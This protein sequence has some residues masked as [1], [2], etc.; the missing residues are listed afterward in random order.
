MRIPY[1][2]PQPPVQ[3]I[4]ISLRPD[5]SV[6]LN[7]KQLLAVIAACLAAAFVSG[8]AYAKITAHIDDP[9]H[10]TQRDIRELDRRLTILELRNDP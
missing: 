6:R 2:V 8:L 5:S 9:N 1:D 3:P 7:I 4:A 10:P